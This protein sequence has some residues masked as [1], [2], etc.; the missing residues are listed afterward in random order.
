MTRQNQAF[1]KHFSFSAH[2]STGF[3]L[4][5]KLYSTLTKISDLE[6]TG[7]FTQAHNRITWKGEASM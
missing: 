6:S 2:L 1:T 7:L 3:S 5:S 4:Q